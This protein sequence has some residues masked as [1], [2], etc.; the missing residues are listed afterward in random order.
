M[1]QG[2]VWLV[3]L[4][5]VGKPETGLTRPGLILSINAMNQNSPR[6]IIAPITS[7]VSRVYPFE[8]FLP[9]GTAGL[10]RDSKIMLDQIRSLD[11]NRLIRRLGIVESDALVQASVIARK[12][13]TA[14]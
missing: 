13:I 2:E 6:L 4:G 5:P 8:I 1:K 7:N 9:S 12:L 14:D 11:K 10:D 3:N